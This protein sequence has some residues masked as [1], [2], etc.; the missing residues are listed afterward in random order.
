MKKW[1]ADQVD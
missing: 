1:V